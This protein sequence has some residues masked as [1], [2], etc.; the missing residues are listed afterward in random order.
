MGVALVV[1]GLYLFNTASQNYSLW[2][3]SSVKYKLQCFMLRYQVLQVTVYYRLIRCIFVLTCFFSPM[4]FLPPLF[5]L[6]P[7]PPTPSFLC[8]SL[9]LYRLYNHLCLFNF[10]LTLQLEVF[11]FAWYSLN[12]FYKL[13]Q[14][15]SLS[16]IG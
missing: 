13:N 8:T 9:V 2:V 12:L 14:L 16:K 1:F 7:P 11:S 5:I 4:L 10:L 6:P 3:V 15:R